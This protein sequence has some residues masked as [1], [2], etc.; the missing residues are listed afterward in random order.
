MRRN[1]IEYIILDGIC[2]ICGGEMSVPKAGPHY[3]KMARRFPQRFAVCADCVCA[4]VARAVYAKHGLVA[5]TPEEARS[6]NHA[7]HW[8][9]YKAHARRI[10]KHLGGLTK[11]EHY[12]KQKSAASVLTIGE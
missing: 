3:D 5:T 6:N 10:R 11:S 9:R 4:W 2:A 7:G 1:Q 12:A 8:T